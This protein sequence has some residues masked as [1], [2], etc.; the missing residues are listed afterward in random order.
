MDA[1]AAYLRGQADA[2]QLP[3]IETSNLS[4]DAIA[5]RSKFISRV[6]EVESERTAGRCPTIARR[7]E[8]RGGASRRSLHGFGSTSAR[9]RSS[10]GRSK[11]RLI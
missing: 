8:G 9:R 5:D 7:A 10:A 4:V 3:V 1:W 2:L 11:S 6:F